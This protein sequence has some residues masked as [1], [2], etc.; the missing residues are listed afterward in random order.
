MGAAASDGHSNLV[1][2]PGNS[3]HSQ[4]LSYVSHAMGNA[5]VQKSVL[6]VDGGGSRGSSPLCGRRQRS[7]QQ[8]QESTK[9]NQ[10]IVKLGGSPPW[11]R[12]CNSSVTT[13]SAALVRESAA[14]R[15]VSPSALDAEFRPAWKR[16]RL[17][18]Q[19]HDAAGLGEGQV[20]S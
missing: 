18:V 13:S 3:D 16:G 7:N 8:L 20:R 11:T 15:R 5:T 1:M 14:R 10:E 9:Q 4:M 2:C 19:K 6:A 12:T 17:V